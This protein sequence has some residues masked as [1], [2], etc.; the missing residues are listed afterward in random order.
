[1]RRN[2]DRGERRREGHGRPDGSERRAFFFFLSFHHIFITL[3]H[4]PSLPPSYLRIPLFLPRCPAFPARA[5]LTD[6]AAI[7][8]VVR[9][10]NPRRVAS[11]HRNRRATSPSME[12]L[13]AQLVTVLRYGTWHRLFLFPTT[14]TPRSNAATSARGARKGAADTLGGVVA[15]CILRSV[16]FAQRLPRPN[17]GRPRRTRCSMQTHKPCKMQLP[18]AKRVRGSRSA[19]YCNESKTSGSCFRK[20]ITLVGLTR[21]AT[22]WLFF[23]E[24]S[25]LIL[26]RWVLR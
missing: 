14:R 3:S 20:P 26:A 7:G 24:P 12:A 2:R 11:H 9:D 15:R 16:H 6:G 13:A 22:R 19:P 1:M 17:R 10:P 8:L 21:T 4:P 5:L 18:D 23:A 25:F